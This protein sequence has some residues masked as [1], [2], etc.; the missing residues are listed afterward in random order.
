MTT[1]E[2][3]TMN[4]C[5]RDACKTRNSS[6]FLVTICY[7]GKQTVDTPVPSTC[8]LVYLNQFIFV[9]LIKLLFW[10]NAGIVFL[11]VQS[12]TSFFYK[13]NISRVRVIA[14]ICSTK[15]VIKFLLRYKFYRIVFPITQHVKQYFGR[16][17]RSKYP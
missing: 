7:Y 16:R 12:P 9:D 8:C 2:L 3:D 5:A 13:Q 4:A 6:M 11:K 10:W 17:L 14:G 15:T 1:Q